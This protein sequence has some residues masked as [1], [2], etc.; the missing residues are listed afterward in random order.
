MPGQDIVN[1]TLLVVTV[2]A[3]TPP[4]MVH[5][6]ILPICTTDANFPVD[7]FD[8]HNLHGTTPPDAVKPVI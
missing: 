6:N 5:A 7:L 1:Q 3:T 8:P 2:G 4:P